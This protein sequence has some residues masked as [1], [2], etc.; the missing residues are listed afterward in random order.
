MNRYIK[1]F[2]AVALLAGAG[3]SLRAD[4][5][6]LPVVELLGNTYYVYKAKKGDSLFG[7][8]RTYGWDDK[9]LQKLNPSAVSPLQKGMKIYYPAPDQRA[10]GAVAPPVSANDTELRHT[11]K[12]GETVYAISNMYGVP[13]DRIY[14]LNPDSRNGIKAWETLLVRKAG[15]ASKAK[16]GSQFYTVRKGDT[17]YGVAREYGVSVAALMKSNPGVDENNFQEGAN[18]RIP[19]R[20]AG[21]EKTRQ[22]VEVSGLDSMDIHKVS[23]KETWGSIASANGVSVETLREANPDVAELKNKEYIAV[24][25]VETVKEEQEVET[26]DPRE[27]APGGIAEI[28][29]DVHKVA[30]DEEEYTVRVAV[31]TENA[32]ANRDIEFLRGF[33]TGI[34]RQKNSGHRIAFKVIDGSASSES[35]ITALDEFK[36]SAVFLTADGDI[37]SYIGE[38]AMVSQTPV[39]NTFDVKSSLYET[40]PYIIQLLTPSTLFNENIAAYVHDRYANRTLIFVGEEDKNDLLAESLRKVWD[41]SKVKT[42]PVA[43]ITPDHFAEDG[44]YLIYG[45]P[46]KKAEVTELLD[47]VIAVRE[48]RPMA[49]ISFLGRPNLIVFEESLESKFHHADVMIPSR[50]YIDR[51]SS[52]YKTF[53]QDFKTLF[54]RAPVKSLPLYAAVGYDT[55]TYFIPALSGSRGD[56]NKLNPSRGTVQSDYDLVRTSN[57]GGFLNPPVFMVRFTPFDTIEKNVID[58]VD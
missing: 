23:K 45:Y 14:A 42:S 41:S 25:R 24:P 18:I 9:T 28:Y 32:A 10:Q 38:Y 50:F 37:P 3:F 54:N 26:V 49:D 46:V 34:D 21:I 35:V 58:Y 16:D 56:V 4:N 5:V 17:L 13:V 30:G 51:E 15:A 57:W 7:I 12:R 19:A 29:Q 53:L 11:V 31:V 47:N 22:V 6:K 44:K 1:S 33:L 39:I 55:S 27:T 48:Q 43:G 40:N 2:L 8:A 20:G 52:A 36:P